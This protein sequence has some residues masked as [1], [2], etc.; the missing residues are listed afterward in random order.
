M[1]VEGHVER[2]RP[3]EDRPKPLV[4]DKDAVREPVDHR[5]LEAKL[6]RPLEFVGCRFWVAR[7]QRC[8]GR[9]P[10]R[11]GG[12]NGMQLP[13]VYLDRGSQENCRWRSEY[14]SRGAHAVS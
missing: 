11:V 6:G 7:G 12:N 4:I 1:Q 14:A 10:L 8:K 5:S 2:L 13:D 9:E 3:L